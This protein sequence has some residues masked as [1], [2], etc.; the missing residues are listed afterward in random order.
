MT[1]D[2][3][4]DKFPIIQ[5]GNNTVNNSVVDITK[6]VD[7][8]NNISSNPYIF[9]PYDLAEYERADQFSHRYYSD[10]YKSWILYIS[11]Q[12]VDP[13]Y[14]WYMRNN[15]FSE[16]IIK[17]Y[18]SIQNAIQKIKYY[19]NNWQP[20]TE[21]NP[22]GYNAL[23]AYM[24]TFWEP[25]YGVNSKIIS[26]KRKEDDYIVNTNKIVTYSVS[27]TE[28]I[29]D[30][31]V[32]IVFDTNNKGTGQIAKS[33][34]NIVYIQ[35]LSGTFLSNTTVTIGPNSYIYGTESTVNTVF[36]S[37]SI[38]A[39]NLHSEVEI[40]FSPVTYYQYEE[41]KNAFNRT[42]RVLDNRLSR[43][44]SNNLKDLLKV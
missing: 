19:R 13:Y 40:Y 16:F 15:E 23:T 10:A 24:K 36:T 25:V 18:G 14:E 9:Y 38:V 27:N 32:N 5:Y 31:I 12:I 29:N 35:H 26:Y 20:S 39:N 41:E 33:G 21:I 42:I 11:N 43:T 6:R 22:S 2:K 4:F 44:V 17:K 37:S 7:L 3:Y 28:F 30:E 34:N 8:L 1:Q